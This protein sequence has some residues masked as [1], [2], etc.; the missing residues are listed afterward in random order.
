MRPVVT[1]P[2]PPP[3]LIL[4]GAPGASLDH[5]DPFVRLEAI[6]ALRG[7]PELHDALVRALSDEYAMVRREAVRA[8]REEGNTQAVRVL[9]EVANNDRSAEVREEAVAALAALLREARTRRSNPA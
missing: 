8:L 6:E 2:P 5:P 1:P 9:V 7:R 4:P 3:P